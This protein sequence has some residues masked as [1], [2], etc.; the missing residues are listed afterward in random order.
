[1]ASV[2]SVLQ[3]ISSGVNRRDRRVPMDPSTEIFGKIDSVFG[4]PRDFDD[5]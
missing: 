4:G 1:M 3:T 5:V 2:G